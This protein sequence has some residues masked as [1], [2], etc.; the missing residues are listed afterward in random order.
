V[1]EAPQTTGRVAPCRPYRIGDHARAIRNRLLVSML[2]SVVIAAPVSVLVPLGLVLALPHEA[3]V[4]ASSVAAAITLPAAFVV[5]HWAL[6]GQRRWAAPEILIWGGRFAAAGF[7][8][9]TG[10][11]NPT[12]RAAAAAWLAS[13]PADDEE[14]PAL[15]YWRA[16]VRLLTGDPDGARA[17]VALLEGVAGYEFA[18]AELLGE[19]DLSEGTPVDVVAVEAAT[20][21]IGDPFQRAIAAANLGALR[22]QLAWTCGRDDV[23]PVLAVRPLVGSHARGFILRR[24]WLPFVAVATASAVV[25]SIVRPFG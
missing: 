17:D 19:I 2:I 21:A 18:R 24:Y 23:A 10:I 14:D 25:L 6:V 12:D 7:A 3:G 20:R 11:R 4:A 22:A 16:Y 5:G 13:Q 8:A 1:A 15:T 9:T